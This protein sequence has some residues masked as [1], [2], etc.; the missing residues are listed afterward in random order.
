MIIAARAKLAF[1]IKLALRIM[2]LYS[3]SLTENLPFLSKI[4][5]T[6]HIQAH[7]QPSK[8]R[9]LLKCR[10]TV[11][12][13]LT[14]SCRSST[15]SDNFLFH[16]HKYLLQSS[17]AFSRVSYSQESFCHQVFDNHDQYCR[18]RCKRRLKI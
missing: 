18:N 5:T 6:L 11:A 10:Y 1:H 15:Y 16:S 3:F 7:S 13:K 17:P 9:N 2:Y 14:L 8:P 12:R 4:N